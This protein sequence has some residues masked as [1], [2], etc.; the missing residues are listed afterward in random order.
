MCHCLLQPLF[1]VCC[2]IGVL[3]ACDVRAEKPAPVALWKLSGDVR[4]HSGN[5]HHG[6]NHG[7]DLSKPA[8]APRSG[9]A[10]FFD[11]RESHVE[12][13]HGEQLELGTDD[14]SITAW[15]HTAED[16][17]DVLGDVLSKYDPRS[18]RGFVLSLKHNVGGTTSQANYRHVQFG[19]DNGRLD[20]SWTD[21]GRPGEA[22]L[23]YALAVHDG[24][25]FAGTCVAGKDKAGRVFRFDGDRSWIDCG[26]PDRCN[27]VS[28]LAVYE[29]KL[30][31]G[32]SKYRLAGSSLTE[33][34]NPHDGGTIYRYEGDRQWVSVGTL[35]DVQ[36]INGMVVYRGKLYA[37]SM[38]A[39]AGLFRYDGDSSWSDCGSPGGKRVEALCVYNGNLFA[40]GYDE[41]AVY[42]YDGSDWTHCGRLGDNTQTYGFAIHHGQLYVSTWRSGRVYRYAGD[43]DWVDVGR[44][45]DELEVMGMAVYNGKL[46]AG[47]LP[48]AAVYRYDGLGHWHNTGRVDRTPEVRY[49]RAWTMAVYDGKLFV[50]TLPSGHVMSI[51]AGKSVTL[52][53]ELPSG[54]VHLAAVKSHDRLKLYLN[55][56][57][58]A[59]SSVFDAADYDLTNTQPLTIGFGPH[60][61]LNGQLSDVR[62]YRQ[63]LSEEDV[64]RIAGEKQGSARP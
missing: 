38:Y 4:D 17:D 16:L 30:Y 31:A 26:A 61:Y 60:D 32:V 59:Q 14:F 27:A 15:V 41:G 56:K 11:G 5:G 25:L 47:T 52:D 8:P 22:V 6:Q 18:R 24:Q 51:E 44:L 36:A 12:V 63:A 50:G 19:I 45:G 20:N 2:I 7:V 3:A 37:S 39:P 35:P 33:S 58:A 28:T 9:R 21:R 40:T 54:W 43:N 49:R 29:G 13:P 34:E 62:L 23:I 1:A 64:E 57:F 10:A 55:G 53:R 42:R 46:Y 48:L